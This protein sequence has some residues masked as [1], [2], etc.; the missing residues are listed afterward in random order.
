MN[1]S[2]ANTANRLAVDQKILS[3]KR[4][5]SVMSPSPWAVFSVEMAVGTPGPAPRE[6]RASQRGQ[7]SRTAGGCLER[8][9]EGSE[10]TAGQA[11]LVCPGWGV[12]RFI[13][14]TPGRT[15]FTQPYLEGLGAAHLMIFTDTERSMV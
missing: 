9:I 13:I 2:E 8:G 10:R 15:V 3:L 12:S 7:E 4:L 5:W 6:E 1:K 14:K 11:E